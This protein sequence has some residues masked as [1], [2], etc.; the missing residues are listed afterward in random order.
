MLLCS[1]PWQ[2]LFYFLLFSSNVLSDFRDL[3]IVDILCKQNN[4]ICDLLCLFFSTQHNAFRFVHVTVCISNSFLFWLN[5]SPLFGY[6]IN[7]ILNSLKYLLYI[8]LRA[9][10]N[11]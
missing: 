11:K 5:S 9:Y 3:P 8:T 6:M 1:S 10:R 4:T 7:W 2:P